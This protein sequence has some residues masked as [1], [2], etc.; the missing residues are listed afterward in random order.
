MATAW[1]DEVTR[2]LHEVRDRTTVGRGEPAARQAQLRDRQGHR[3]SSTP[4]D[5][6]AAAVAAMTGLAPRHRRAPGHRGYA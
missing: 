4:E 5:A 6:A 2:E 1:Y 3:T